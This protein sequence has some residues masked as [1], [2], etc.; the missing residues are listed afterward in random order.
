ML[1]GR[2]FLLVMDADGQQI[3]VHQAP[4]VG[5]LSELGRPFRVE[6][7]PV[8]SGDKTN[9]TIARALVSRSAAHDRRPCA[10]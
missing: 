8:I 6:E 3:V 5:A 7:H 10:E 2:R 4:G 9:R 1:L